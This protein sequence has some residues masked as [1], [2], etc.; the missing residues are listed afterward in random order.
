MDPDAREW[1][2]AFLAKRPASYPRKR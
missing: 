1:M 2:A